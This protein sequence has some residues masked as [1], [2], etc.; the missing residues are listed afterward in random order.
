MLKKISREKNT[1]SER[2]KRTLPL[3]NK[4]KD[5]WQLISTCLRHTKSHNF[6]EWYALIARPLIAKSKIKLCTMDTSLN[7]AWTVKFINILLMQFHC[8]QFLNFCGPVILKGFG[9]VNCV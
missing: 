8:K 2:V 1:H 7:S 4:K 5:P 3:D 9:G 6:D